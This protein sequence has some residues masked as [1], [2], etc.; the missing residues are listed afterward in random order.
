MSILAKHYVTTMP[1]GEKWSVPV[2]VIAIDRAEYYASQ[3]GGDVDRSLREDTEPLFESD[4]YE[5]EDWAKNN[6]NWSDVEASA[7][8]AEKGTC[9]YQ[10]GWVNGDAEVL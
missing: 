1:N 6:M 5:I 7:T 2:N 8:L 10:E 9:D 4:T 3:F